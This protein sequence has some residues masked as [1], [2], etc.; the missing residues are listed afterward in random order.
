[1]PDG[2]LDDTAAGEAA[3]TGMKTFIEA[4]DPNQAAS[5]DANAD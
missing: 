5:G 2:N 1:M 3:S 4:V